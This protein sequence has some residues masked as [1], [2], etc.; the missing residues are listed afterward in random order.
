MTGR[1]GFPNSVVTNDANISL[2]SAEADIL[3]SSS[4]TN[5]LATLTGN[6]A[7]GL[8]SLASGQILTTNG[9][10]SNAGKVTVGLGSAF[11]PKGSYKQTAGQTTVDGTLNA[12]TG[13]VLSG[14]SLLALGTPGSSR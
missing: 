14:G 2:A 13:L 12:P 1:L 6:A 11:H 10:F 3:S 8:L 9:N 4:N 5:A 7:A